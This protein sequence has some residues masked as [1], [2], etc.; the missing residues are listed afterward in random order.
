MRK[1]MW[2]YLFHCEWRADLFSSEDH[3]TLGQNLRQLKTVQTQELAHVSDN[4]RKTGKRIINKY[5]L[6]VLGKLLTNCSLLLITNYMRK[7]I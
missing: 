1:Y 2:F 3:G 4:C 6:A 7:K 5:I